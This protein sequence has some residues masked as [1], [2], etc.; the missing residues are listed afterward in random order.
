ME[1][2]LRICEI[3]VVAGEWRSGPGRWFVSTLGHRLP[4]A[5]FVLSWYILTK[6]LIAWNGRDCLAMFL[7]GVPCDPTLMWGYAARWCQAFWPSKSCLVWKV[8][9][10]SSSHWTIHS[11]LLSRA[12]AVIA[13]FLFFLL[14]GRPAHV[15]LHL[16]ESLVRL[17]GTNQTT[18]EQIKG[19]FSSLAAQLE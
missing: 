10:D 15:N 13:S 5:W 6:H 14:P 1:P 16:D 3:V 17:Q 7:K 9:T 4:K 19:A 12:N 8:Y 2:L 11:F 18:Y